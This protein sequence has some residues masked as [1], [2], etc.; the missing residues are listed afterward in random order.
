MTRA[1]CRGER[2]RGL[3]G[4]ALP[5]AGLFLTDCGGRGAW[6]GLMTPSQTDGEP[7]FAREVDTVG[8]KRIGAQLAADARGL[9]CQKSPAS[10][11]LGPDAA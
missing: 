10:W 5:A 2:S 9:S 11:A 4:S 6:S 7:G 3:V 1:L 8:D